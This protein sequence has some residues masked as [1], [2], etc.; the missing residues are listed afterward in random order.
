MPWFSEFSMCIGWKSP[1]LC[2][3]SSGGKNNNVV[4]IQLFL[5]TDSD[6][7][8]DTIRIRI[9]FAPSDRDTLTFHLISDYRRNKIIVSK[10]ISI[11]ITSS[12]KLQ[13]NYSTSLHQN[14]INNAAYVSCLYYRKAST[15][16]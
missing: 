13:S 10:R 9:Q 7:H 5:N 1:P 8:A 11:A 16:F 6:L 15:L 12:K 3:P 2:L 4:M 14:V